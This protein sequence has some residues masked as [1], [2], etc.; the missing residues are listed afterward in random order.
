MIESNIHP[1]IFTIEELTLKAN[2]WNKLAYYLLGR[3]YDSGENNVEQDFNKAF[4]YYNKGMQL[5]D[6][7]S[8]YGVAA[9]YYFGDGCV[10]DKNLANSIFIQ[11]YPKLIEQIKL[12]MNYPHE[13]CFPIFCLGAYYYF[14]FGNID[15]D[16]ELAFKHIYLSAMQGHIAG[17]YDLGANFYYNGIGTQK[18]LQKAKFFLDLASNYG[19][20]R[21]KDKIHEYNFMEKEK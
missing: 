3:S 1:L 12:E 2:K 5:G 9:C 4:Y 11:T 21:A 7:C 6:P 14:G 10:E 19:L 15:K 16:Y 8:S 18:N 13:Q 20:K 17:I